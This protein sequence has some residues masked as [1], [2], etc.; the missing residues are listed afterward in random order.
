M[1][2]YVGVN[3]DVAKNI[4]IN[5]GYPVKKLRKFEA[6]HYLYVSDFITNR[7]NKKDINKK[8]KIVLVVVDI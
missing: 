7:K 6:L 2:S 1:P 3:G 4:Y 8:E 5:G